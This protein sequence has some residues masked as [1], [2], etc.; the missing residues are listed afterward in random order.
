MKELSLE[1]VPGLVSVVTANHDYGRYLVEGLESLR[2]QTYPHLEVVIVD[3][4]SRDDSARLVRGWLAARRPRFRVFFHELPRNCGY[5]WAMNVGIS[6]AKGELIAFQDADDLSH[7]ERL[8]RQVAWFGLH[9]DGGLLGTNFT[10]FDDGRFDRQRQAFWLKYGE[11]ISACYRAGGHCVSTGTAM[12]RGSV[13]DRLGPFNRR[14]PGAE[15]YEL[16]ARIVGAG[17][18]VDNLRE[19]LYHNRCHPGKRSRLYYGKPET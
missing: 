13:I 3:D 15:D 2:L 7:P 17:Y 4:H 11:D 14:C 6:L 18:L 9:A 12:V 1:R 16:V 19:V 10:A 5:A 8:A